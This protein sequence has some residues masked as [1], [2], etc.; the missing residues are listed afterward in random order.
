MRLSVH[1]LRNEQRRHVHEIDA[2][3]G[4]LRRLSEQTVGE[5]S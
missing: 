2:A 3:L 1:E 4:L 5:S